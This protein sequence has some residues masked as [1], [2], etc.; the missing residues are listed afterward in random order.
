MSPQ[1]LTDAHVITLTRPNGN[2]YTVKLSDLKTKDTPPAALFTDSKIEAGK[3][4]TISLIVNETGVGISATIADWENKT[5]SGTVT[6]D[7]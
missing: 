6:P 4:Y 2:T 1:T 7:F 5:G 3:H